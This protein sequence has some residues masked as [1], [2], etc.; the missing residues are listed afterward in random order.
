MEVE[1]NVVQLLVQGNEMK[2]AGCQIKILSSYCRLGLLNPKEAM[3]ANII[4]VNIGQY[5]G[6]FKDKLLAG[7]LLIGVRF[8]KNHRIHQGDKVLLSR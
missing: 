3:K 2:V 6:T 5:W 7:K 4:K 1:N 8:K